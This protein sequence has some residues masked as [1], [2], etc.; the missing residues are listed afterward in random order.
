MIVPSGVDRPSRLLG[1]TRL[2]MV[3]RG[4][5]DE[6]CRVFSCNRMGAEFFEGPNVE[7]DLVG[8]AETLVTTE[9][10]N[11]GNVLVVQPE[12]AQRNERERL[13]ERQDRKFERRHTENRDEPV[14]LAAHRSRCTGPIVE[15]SLADDELD[16]PPLAVKHVL[17]VHPL[18]D[19]VIDVLLSATEQS[20]QAIR[21]KRKQFTCVTGGLQK[22]G[23]ERWLVLRDA[24]SFA[25]ELREGRLMASQST[26]I[27]GSSPPRGCVLESRRFDELID[28]GGYG[29]RSTGSR[30]PGLKILVRRDLHAA[31]K[32]RHLRLHPPEVTGQC[33]SGG[34]G[35]GAKRS[36]LGAQPSPACVDIR[37]HLLQFLLVLRQ[38]ACAWYERGY[39]WA[40]VDVLPPT[41][42]VAH[43]SISVQS[44]LLDR[45]W[46]GDVLH[47]GKFATVRVMQDVELLV[48]DQREILQRRC[49]VDSDVNNANILACLD[50]GAVLPSKLET[51]VLREW[52]DHGMDPSHTNAV[53]H[54]VAD[55]VQISI[56][57]GVPR[58]SE[59]GTKGCERGGF[60]RRFVPLQPFETEYLRSGGAEGGAEVIWAW[61]GGRNV[62]DHGVPPW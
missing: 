32:A 46:L 56:L 30:E 20:H 33:G 26:G 24:V 22:G 51:H 17:A 40:R 3:L 52:F 8:I 55:P 48:I 9:S 21:R 44:G 4:A 5:A 11:E 45:S 18:L 2:P 37:R 57:V 43:R 39:A 42:G 16:D 53:A 7:G 31:L 50:V 41:G 23:Q 54:L 27:A 36:Q 19:E 58:G 13:G 1:S 60:S 49:G 61:S 10:L 47:V 29:L 6:S 59:P 35:G 62:A 12:P 34:K 38:N 14:E 15:S 25:L 28:F